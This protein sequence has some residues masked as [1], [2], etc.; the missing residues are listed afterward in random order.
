MNYPYPGFTCK[1]M[2]PQRKY[3]IDGDRLFSM[4][5]W[6]FSSIYRLITCQM[7]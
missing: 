5:V 4:V 3:S 6:I 1:A 7:A 2:N